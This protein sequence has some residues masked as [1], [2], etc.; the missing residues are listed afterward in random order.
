MVAAMMT[1]CFVSLPRFVAVWQ[2]VSEVERSLQGV[3]FVHDS[4]SM[5]I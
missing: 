5:S 3:S 2:E 4:S 1:D